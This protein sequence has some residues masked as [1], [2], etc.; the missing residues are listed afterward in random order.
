M[1]EIILSHQASKFKLIDGNI[2]TVY[3]GMC[4]SPGSLRS[5]RNGGLCAFI[6]H[7]TI[8]ANVMSEQRCVSHCKL[9]HSKSSMAGMVLYMLCLYLCIF[10]EKKIMKRIK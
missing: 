5:V 7:V 3:E 2:Q 9:L 1:S 6:R 10:K 8:L 4:E